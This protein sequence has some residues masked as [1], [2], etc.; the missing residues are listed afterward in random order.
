MPF[1]R[2]RRLKCRL[3]LAIHGALTLPCIYYFSCFFTGHTGSRLVHALSYAAGFY[4]GMLFYAALLFAMADLARCVG[5]LFDYPLPVRR[6]GA[7]LY[8][9]GLPILLIAALFSCFGLANSQVR[10]VAAYELTLPQGSSTLSGLHA[11]MLADA[12]IGTVV[13]ED[14]LRQIVR[15]VNALHPDIVFLCGDLFDEG[16]TSAQKQAASALFGSIRSRYG[17]YSITGNHEYS[18][19]H[20]SDD[21]EQLQAAGIHLL[22]DENVT[23]DKQFCVAGRLDAKSHNRVPLS[24]VLDGADGGLPLIL[25]D[26]RP[27]YKEAARSGQVDLLL[28]GHTH[29]GQVFPLDLLDFLTP[30]LFYGYYRQGAMQ[31][32]VTS[33]AGAWA[34]PLRLGSTCEIVDLHI[35][36][37]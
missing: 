4:L 6:W 14:E 32:V 36:F 22:G 3:A 19:H 26:H 12:H 18:S 11:V 7:R 34:I 15:Q 30:S 20:V 27:Q 10:T 17:T 28:S 13:R 5:R 1:R 25:L 8:Y 33:G 2:R 24:Q 35:H 16:T 29:N 21:L 23:V 31:A 37:E 9:R